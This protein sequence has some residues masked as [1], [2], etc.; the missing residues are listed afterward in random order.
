MLFNPFEVNEDQYYTPLCEIDPDINYYNSIGSHLGTNCNYYY[1]GH[2]ET[3]L[4]TKCIDIKTRNTLSL[5]HLNI[6]S[7]RANLSSFEICLNNMNYNFSVIGL[8]ET[9]LRDHNCN[10]YNIENYTF[11]EVHR[12]ERAGGGVGLFV[13]DDIPFHVRTDMCGITDIYEC[14]FV[15]IDKDCFHKEKNIIMGVIYRPLKCKFSMKIWVS[16]LMLWR[17]KTST[18]TWWAIIMST[19][20]TMGN[21]KKHLSWT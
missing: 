4:K 13:K 18:V 7:M 8:S 3:A 12:T 16:C 1:E 2:F 15:E 5:C 17:M 19:Y 20:L 10:L 11:T 21:T 9:W 6:R 14:V